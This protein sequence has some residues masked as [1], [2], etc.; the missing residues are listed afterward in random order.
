MSYW[1][2]YTY[3]ASGQRA[4]ET[5]NTAVQTPVTT[6]YC[7]DPARKHALKST[8]TA[9]TCDPAAAAQYTYDAAGNTETRVE[10]AGST[11]KQSLL[12]NSEGRLGKLTE[13]TAATDYL[14]DADGTL[15]IRRSTAT[16]GETVLYLGAT[17]VHLKSGKKWANRY[18]AVGGAN[19]AVRSNAS[20]TEKVHYL[21]GDHHGTS[22]VSI[23]SD[24]TQSLSKRYTTPFGTS[25]GSTVGTWPDDK[26]FL[27]KS[28]DSS[29]G[30]TQVGAREYDTSTGQFLSVDP[31]LM[32]DQHQ[33]LNGYGYGYANNNP[34]TVADPSGLG[35]PECHTGEISCTGGIP[36]TEE[37]RK[38]K[39]GKPKKKSAAG[40][41][42][43]YKDGRSGSAPPGAP[44]YSRSIEEI[45]F[46]N[47]EIAAMLRKER[48]NQI[49]D[50][51]CDLS[52]PWKEMAEEV[53]DSVRCLGGVREGCTGSKLGE[54]LTDLFGAD[55]EDAAEIM[56][57]IDESW[58][59]KG[60][61]KKGGEFAFDH[62]EFQ[63]ALTLAIT[64]KSVMS[65]NDR[66]SNP[67]RGDAWVDDKRA[68]FK[69][70]KSRRAD[71]IKDHLKKADVDQQVE[72]AVVDLRPGGMEE[73]DARDG[74]RMFRNSTS[75]GNIQRVIVFGRGYAIEY[76]L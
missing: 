59:A 69:A 73:D 44:R 28:A 8:T 15:L 63:I 11:T 4:T 41:S 3:T 53:E 40:T 72:L 13:S 38:A 24:S 10:S 66:Q 27:G 39:G 22:T 54:A 75:R 2:S 47:H 1:T 62:D 56:A 60:T 30:L 50:G 14:Y 51:E 49:L 5:R 67:H 20:G 48:V 16:D 58:K 76:D 57:R 52:D 7:Y 21:S 45:L 18:Y 46:T 19:I 23:S 42:Y 25:R 32:P 26:G 36:D 29:T 64:G 9:A 17:E 61:H 55:Q 65:R 12:W 68:D 33:S 6:T 43:V 74:L 31:L 34:T 37:E 70:M 35:V 71:G